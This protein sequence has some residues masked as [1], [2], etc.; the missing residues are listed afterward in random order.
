VVP[1]MVS[2]I[3]SEAQAGKPFLILPEFPMLYVL[4]GTESPSRWYTLFPGMLD[5][6]AEKQ[7][8]SDA[9][10][11]QIEYVIITNRETPDYGYPYFGIDWGQQI[12]RWVNSNFEPAGEF[13][14]F[15]RRSDAPLGALLYKR[16]RTSE[17]PARGASLPQR[18][19]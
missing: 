2:F 10:A 1:K 3:R 12:Y 11:R 19:R 13:G 16:K 15:E 6:E 5:D 14:K 8:I 17:P 9:E 7:F 4:S 18:P